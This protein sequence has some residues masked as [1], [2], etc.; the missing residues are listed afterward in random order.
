MSSIHSTRTSFFS[1]SGWY[2]L[3]VA[4]N[5]IRTTKLAM[6]A[7]AA[8]SLLMLNARVGL[9]LDLAFF[10]VPACDDRLG[11]FFPDLLGV[12]LVLFIVGILFGEI[13]DRPEFFLEEI[14]LVV[15]GVCLSSCVKEQ[16]PCLFV[17]LLLD[18]KRGGVLVVTLPKVGG[19]P[20]EGLIERHGA[21]CFHTVLQ[22]IV[23]HG[24]HFL[25]D[26]VFTFLVPLKAKEA[27]GQ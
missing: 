1:T 9:V 13:E 19:E 6:A 12:L 24:V 8:C 7:I 23:H 3:S 17:V 21:C 26:R 4:M 15:D 25:W 22:D 14:F 16:S 10:G 27:K 20:H 18:G 2:F 11:T 5:S